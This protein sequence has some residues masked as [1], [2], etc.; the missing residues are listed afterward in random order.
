MTPGNAVIPRTHNESAVMKICQGQVNHFILIVVAVISRKQCAQRD[1]LL[2]GH[3]CF[4]TG[5]VL[6]PFF[7]RPH[8]LNTMEESL[9]LEET[10]FQQLPTNYVVS[11]E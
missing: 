4:A 1:W 8:L 9:A 11:Y 6:S 7:V 5:L 2:Q 3:R 10:V